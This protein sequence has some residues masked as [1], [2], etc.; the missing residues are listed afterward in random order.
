MTYVQAYEDV[1]DCLAKRVPAVWF[2]SADETA[3]KEYME[4]CQYW[5]NL[6][7]KASILTTEEEL[8]EKETVT[9]LKFKNNT[10]IVAL[11]SNP[12]AFRSKGGKVVL[13]EFAFHDHANELYRAAKPTITSMQGLFPLRIISTHNGKSC[14]YYKFLEAAKNGKMPWSYHF[15]DIHKA[16]E[17]GYLDKIMGR[18]TT[19]E[20][21]TKWLL[22]EQAATGD[23]SVWLQEYCCI[24]VDE[25]TAWLTFDL[26]KT[27]EVEDI[28]RR[29]AVKYDKNSGD[30]TITDLINDV[31]GFLAELYGITYKDSRFYVG[32]DI[33]RNKDLTAIWLIEKIGSIHYTRLLVEMENTPYSQQ[34]RFLFWLFKLIRPKRSCFDATGIGDMLAESCQEE[35]GQYRVEKVK[36]TMQVKED[37]AVNMKQNFED[38][39]ILIPAVDILRT[40]LHSIQKLTTS[41][42]NIRFD[43]KRSDVGHA[44]RFWS[45]ALALHAINN[46][47]QPLINCIGSIGTRKMIQSFSAY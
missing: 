14:R 47:K 19:H 39:L 5:A 15:V 1:E 30:S 16:V 45:G 42:G 21:R 17:Q 46:E 18:K 33:G 27:C 6:V 20:E 40:D 7:Q 9:T 43:A 11:S 31:S 32:V 38:R 26:I 29:F 8:I 25:S 35:F 28:G 44:D 34:Q 41:S 3:A 36:F 37:L 23:E 4:Y 12:K 22:E 13:D 10:K 24:P 2:S